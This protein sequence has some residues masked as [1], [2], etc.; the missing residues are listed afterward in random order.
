MFYFKNKKFY[1]KLSIGLILGLLFGTPL[2][3]QGTQATQDKLI[4]AI[5]VIRHGDRTPYTDFKNPPYVWPEGLGQLT[6]LGMSQEYN[7][8][9]KMH[10]I[11]MNDYALLPESYL[12]STMR[13]RSTDYD[14]TLMSAESLLMGLYPIGF[15][16][17]HTQPIPVH[18]TALSQDDVLHPLANQQLAKLVETYIFPEADWQAKQALLQPKFAAWSEATGISITNLFDLL[19]IGD[20]LYVRQQNQVPL[21]AGLSPEDVQAIINASLWALVQIFASPV[22]AHAG[23][24]SLLMQIDQYLQDASQHKTPLKYVLYSGHDSTILPLLS[25][26]QV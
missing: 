1:L 15:G 18:T 3:A 10:Q 14:R 25:D 26:L 16:P 22:I 12:A 21:P 13:V 11:Y 20:A 8:G 19:P 7:L 23:A 5:D 9:Q 24:H 6:P 2:W 17:N 4:F